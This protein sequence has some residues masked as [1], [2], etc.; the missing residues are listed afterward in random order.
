MSQLT[1]SMREHYILDSRDRSHK[2]FLP[3]YIARAEEEY[4]QFVLDHPGYSIPFEDESLLNTI[5]DWY[6]FMGEFSETELI[7]LKNTWDL[8]QHDIEFLIEGE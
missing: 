3:D 7:Y 8:S 6:G 4:N 5:L 1:I 2:L